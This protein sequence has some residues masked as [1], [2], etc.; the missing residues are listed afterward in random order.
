MAEMD[1]RGFLRGLR[2]SEKEETGEPA[3][4]P[5]PDPDIVQ[6]ADLTR[7]LLTD[8]GAEDEEQ[9]VEAPLL[10][11]AY[12][13][14]YMRVTTGHIVSSYITGFSVFM[15]TGD[16][17]AFE[18]E[19]VIEDDRGHGARILGILHAHH[20]ADLPNVTRSHAFR[21]PA[22]SPLI[23]A[24]REACDLPEPEPEP[25]PESEPDAESEPEA[26]GSGNGGGISRG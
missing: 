16:V 21:F 17:K 2:R 20:P 7:S 13:R 22:D 23:E 12:D 15:K 14:A 25:E 5:P 19:P 3:A 4:P 26:Q 9:L 8:L 6:L 1:R 18:T 10:T 11:S 24:I